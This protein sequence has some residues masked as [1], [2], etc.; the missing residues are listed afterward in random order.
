MYSDVSPGDYYLIDTQTNNARFLVSSRSWVD[1][2]KMR[3]KEP[4]K[5]QARDGLV[6]HGYLTRP[7]DEPGPYPLI[8]L[9]HG[10]PIGVRDTWSF[11]WEAQLFAH[12]GYAVLQVNYRGSAG[13]G[14]A[15]ERAGYR[16]WGGKM[17]DDVTDATQWA[18]AQGIATKDN[19]CIYGASYGGYAAL[20]GAVREPTLY[21]CAASYAGV[22][23][24]Q[25]MYESGDTRYSNVGR[26]YLEEVFGADP[27]FLRARSPAYN[28]DR[29]GIPVLII[30]G[31]ADWRADYEHAT[32]MRDALEKAHKDVQFVPLKF[33]GHGAY[34]EE[35]RIQVYTTLLDFLAK[36]LR[37]GQ[38]F[39]ANSAV[40]VQP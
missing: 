4:V 5:L 35:N 31:K 15:F 8:V 27:E 22:T 13:Y 26:T 14:D 30:H 37:G 32:R 16:E 11:N 10:G 34:D 40:P 19:I 21:Q 7:R 9:P 20:M 29:I 6:L 3:H 38:T 2:K 24:L 17:Q 28:A 18:I 1:P 33:E 23:D 12:Y 25:L 39:T 36:Y